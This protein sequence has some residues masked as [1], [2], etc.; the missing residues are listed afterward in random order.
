MVIFHSYVNVYQR[1]IST[2]HLPCC[3]LLVIPQSKMV[4]CF[5]GKYIGHRGKITIQKLGSN[6]WDSLQPMGVHTFGETLGG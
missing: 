5:Q 6:S 4:D 3:N 1:V 2:H